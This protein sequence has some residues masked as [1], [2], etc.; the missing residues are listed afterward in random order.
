MKN[1]KINTCTT[2][3]PLYVKPFPQVMAHLSFFLQDQASGKNRPRFLIAFSPF[4]FFPLS[5]LL[6]TT[7]FGSLHQYLTFLTESPLTSLS[8]NVMDSS[9]FTL[10]AIVPAF[11]TVNDSVLQ[12]PPPLLF[13]RLCSSLFLLCL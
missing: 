6:Q 13:P 5:F 2:Q 9:V 3:I 10:H 11:E 7:T 1:S 4:S 8:N 12:T